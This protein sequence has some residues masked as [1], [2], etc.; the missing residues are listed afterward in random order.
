M[1]FLVNNI[2]IHFDV[3][4]QLRLIDDYF[5]KGLEGKKQ[6]DV[7]FFHVELRLDHMNLRRMWFLLN[8]HEREANELD[9]LFLNM[10]HD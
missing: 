9:D 3:V 10:V 5:R 8:N 2:P 4:D 7:Y 1:H 6:Q